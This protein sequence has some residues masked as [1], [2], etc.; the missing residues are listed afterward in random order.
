MNEVAGMAFEII[1]TLL[2]LLSLP[3][4]IYLLTLTLAGALPAKSIPANR[5]AGRIAIVV[6]AHDEESGIVGTV[7]NLR[8]LAIK[9]GET[10][11]I[12][13]A[14]NCTDRTAEK[15]EQAGARVWIRNRPDLRGKGHALHEVFTALLEEGFIAFV[16]IDADSI[17]ENNLLTT[18]RQY[19]ADGAM[20]IQIRNE[21]ANANGNL[22]TR[23][24]A[25]ALSAFNVLRPR[26]R[27][28]LGLSAG[29]Q[30]NGFA[31]H[32]NALLRQPYLAGSVVEDLEYHL[33]LTQSGIQVRFAYETG[34]R[35]ELPTGKK[36]IQSQRARWEGGR[37]RMMRSHIP[38]LFQRLLKGNG[39]ALEPLL[40]LLLL[41][42]AYHSSLILLAAGLF[43]VSAN[44]TGAILA[45]LSLGILVLHLLFAIWVAKL[46]PRYLLS[47]VYIPFYMIWKIGMLPKTLIQSRAHSAW[48]RTDRNGH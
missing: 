2:L 35:S 8:S 39:H 15:A 25:I 45:G 1:A 22:R 34:V 48:V 18:L 31:L 6:P 41:P 10:D 42:L 11:V 46:P 7:Q 4:S 44:A 12:V 26:G 19:L 27:A 5:A 24:L 13:I 33:L 32:R 38:A 16:V 20:A 30:G 40:E 23:V 9:D 29:I 47:L 14:D 43:L 21:V 17:A 28:R 37:F 3:G 36:G